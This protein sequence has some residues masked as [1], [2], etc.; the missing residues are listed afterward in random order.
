MDQK[1]VLVFFMTV[2][3]LDGICGNSP[4]VYITRQ[5][6]KSVNISEQ[7]VVELS[8]STRPK[9]TNLTCR[10]DLGP[11]TPRSN[12]SGV[13]LT[14]ESIGLSSKIAGACVDN[15]IN[16]YDGSERLN[17]Q[18]LCG[19][20]LDQHTYV[21]NSSS[22]E[23]MGIELKS[24]DTQQ[25]DISFRAVATPYHNAPCYSDEFQCDNGHCIS[26]DLICNK[27]NNCG[28]DSDEWNKLCGLLYLSVAAIVGIILGSLALI[29]CLPC[30]FILLCCRKGRRRR[31]M[32]RR[33]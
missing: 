1:L 31:G 27:H 26:V 13:V 3:L 18:D 16:I 4:K 33:I 15:S 11:H 19:R 25:R 22:H 9:L 24:R 20:Y 21:T 29:V 17:K 23:M 2:V 8:P 12:E 32:Y 7:T 14:I 5:C 6:G 28:D 30:L 10:V